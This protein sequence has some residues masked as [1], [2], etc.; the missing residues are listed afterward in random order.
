MLLHFPFKP[1]N[2]NHSHMITNRGKFSRLIKTKECRVFE[3]QMAGWL[4]RYEKDK[5]RFLKQYEAK[6]HSIIL[7]LYIGSPTLY[8]KKGTINKKSQ[9][10]DAF[11]V[12][13]DVLFKW[14]GIDDSQ[15]THAI[16]KK[17]Q[18]E[19]EEFYFD[20]AKHSIL[21]HQDI[22]MVMQT[23]QIS[24]AFGSY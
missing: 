9:D 8:T 15:V 11:K 10:F 22:H 16:I 24:Q 12:P 17:C 2:R 6:E 18:S 13:T 4:L 1:I 21:A 19:K 14:L 5:Q 20:V 3:D 7:Q 23:D